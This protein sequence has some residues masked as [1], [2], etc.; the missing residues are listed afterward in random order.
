M[1][2]QG[3]IKRQQNKEFRKRYN[4]MSEYEKESFEAEVSRTKAIIAIVIIA[5][6]IIGF[7]IKYMVL[8]E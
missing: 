8:S 2:R 4:S 6:I 5:I 1:Y 7:L 3:D